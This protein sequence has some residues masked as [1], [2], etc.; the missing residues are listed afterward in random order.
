MDYNSNIKLLEKLLK[1]TETNSN[2]LAFSVFLKKLD[3]TPGCNPVEM[4]L[5]KNLFRQEMNEPT[6]FKKIRAACKNLFVIEYRTLFINK[7]ESEI[8][9]QLIK[10]PF[11]TLK[12]IKKQFERF[13]DSQIHLLRKESG[14]NTYL[15]WCKKE[16]KEILIT[17]EEQFQKL[18]RLYFK[19]EDV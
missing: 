14:Y 19:T 10:K 12:Y 11:E 18:Y 4:T 5:L 7:T 15:N 13:I 2:N 1:E 17:T 6:S 3:I 16:R 9:N 8:K